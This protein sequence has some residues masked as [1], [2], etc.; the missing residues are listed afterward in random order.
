VASDPGQPTRL[1]L[2]EAATVQQAAAEPI[3]DVPQGLTSTAT[4]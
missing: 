4:V 2:N 3:V 1:A